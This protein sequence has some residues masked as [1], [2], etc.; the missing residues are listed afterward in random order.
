MAIYRTILKGEVS[1]PS[2][3]QPYITFGHDF[4]A[5]C[6]EP[7]A[8][9]RL[10]GKLGTSGARQVRAH[11]WFHEEFRGVPAISWSKLER[12]EVKP[13]FVPKISVPPPTYPCLPPAHA[14]TPAGRPAH[15][16]GFTRARRAPSRLSGVCCHRPAITP[17]YGPMLHPCLRCS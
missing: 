13:P 6:L 8:L 16:T 9:K 14:H 15:L 11:T 1:W 5:S 17:P 3:L 2:N 4:I 12:K 7:D 10:G